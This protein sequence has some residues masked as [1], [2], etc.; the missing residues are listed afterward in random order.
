MTD[1]PKSGAAKNPPGLFQAREFQLAV[2][3][4]NKLLVYPQQ[5]LQYRAFVC[6]GNNGLLVKSILKTRPW[7]SMRSYS[8]M[9]S[10]NLV[11]T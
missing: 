5:D 4:T 3:L 1:G 2:T 11:W 10:C 8:E 6:K 9:D 7:W